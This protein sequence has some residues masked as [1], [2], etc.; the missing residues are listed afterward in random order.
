M[1]RQFA[2]GVDVNTAPEHPTGDRPTVGKTIS[3]RHVPGSPPRGPSQSLALQLYGIQGN[4]TRGVRPSRISHGLGMIHASTGVRA[5]VWEAHQ[6]HEQGP[7]PVST[8]S[9]TTQVVTGAFV[10]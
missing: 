3:F 9:R 7:F 8:P 10:F 6:T 2:L 5:P 1:P 4:S